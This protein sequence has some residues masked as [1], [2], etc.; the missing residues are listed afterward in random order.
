M[1]DD[2]S[3]KVTNKALSGLIPQKEQPK[4]TTSY[5]GSG[6][7]TRRSA[8]DYGRSFD[9]FDDYPIGGRGFFDYDAGRQPTPRTRQ[10]G[11]DYDGN[12]INP[13]VHQPAPLGSSGISR[14]QA[15]GHDDSIVSI[16]SGNAVIEEEGLRTLSKKAARGV[17]DVLDGALVVLRSNDL[18]ALEECLYDAL[19]GIIDNAFYMRG[20]SLIPMVLVTEEVGDDQP[21]AVVEPEQDDFEKY[22]HYRL[23]VNGELQGAWEQITDL[24]EADEYREAVL[25]E[26]SN[27]TIVEP[28]KPDLA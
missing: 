9:D 14:R 27:I 20:G 6:G 26:D 19:T 11:Y 7:S 1:S 16:I 28:G 23:Y 22:P 5:R 4:K 12:P 21:E 15:L 24:L 3:K 17:M 25:K 2:I 18:K 10:P 13:R 8:F